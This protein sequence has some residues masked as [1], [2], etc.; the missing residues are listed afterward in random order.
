LKRFVI[1]LF[2]V[3]PGPFFMIPRIAASPFYTIPVH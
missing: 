2:W 3:G 1:V